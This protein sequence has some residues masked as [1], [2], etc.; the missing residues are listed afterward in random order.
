[1]TQKNKGKKPVTDGEVDALRKGLTTVLSSLLE[2]AK[3]KEAQEGT[4][5]VLQYLPVASSTITGLQA[6]IEGK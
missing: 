1:M 6:Q 3:F 5:P 4:V 2:L